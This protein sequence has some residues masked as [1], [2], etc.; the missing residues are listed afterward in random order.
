METESTTDRILCQCAPGCLH[1]ARAS[2]LGHIC[3]RDPSTL[4]GVV[5]YC[6]RNPRGFVAKLR[7]FGPRSFSSPRFWRRTSRI[8]FVLLRDVFAGS[9]PQTVLAKKGA[10]AP[11]IRGLQ[12]APSDTSLNRNGPGC[13]ERE[14]M[15]AVL[16]DAIHCLAGEI[17][18]SRER[19]QLAAEAREWL[20]SGGTPGPRPPGNIFDA[21]GFDVGSPRGRVV[22]QAPGIPFA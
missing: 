14:L 17:G 20:P 22:R 18:P 13:G 7:E 6:P 12:E 1:G 21:I 9:P 8:I 5:R 15:R 3:Y 10:P 11:M 2:K 16:E 19:P 4:R